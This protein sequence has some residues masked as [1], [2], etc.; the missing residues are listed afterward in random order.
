MFVC[1]CDESGFTGCNHDRNQPVTVVA[2]VLVNTYNM[3]KTRADFASLTRKA[4]KLL[5]EAGLGSFAELKAQELYSGSG[6]WK[7]ID[8][9]ERHA[10]YGAMLKWL[11]QRKHKVVASVIDDKVFCGKVASKDP[12][13]TKLRAPYVAGALHLSL[14]VQRAN[15]GAAKNKGRT[16]LIFDAQGEF[17]KDVSQ[18]LYSPPSWTDDYYG[19]R[20]GERLDQVVDTAYFVRSHQASFI[21]IADLVAYVLR[22]HAELTHHGFGEK[23]TGESARTE[24]W[25]SMLRSSM[26]PRPHV[27]PSA[28]GTAAGFLRSVADKSYLDLLG[29]K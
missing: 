15:Q 14:M 23:Y 26:M 22:K 2:G 11:C 12:L 21:Q 3:H 19:Y 5:K 20:R 25:A 24:E 9:A 1:Y 17:E 18:L 27:F 29:A 13:S 8:G 7:G 4:K 16:I 10:L 28:K 6:P